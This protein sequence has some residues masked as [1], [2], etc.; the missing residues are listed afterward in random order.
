MTATATP[1][2]DAVVIW[3]DSARGHDDYSGATRGTALRTLDEAWG[4]VPR[5]RQLVTPYR[6]L[7]VRGTYPE[8]AIPNYLE[9]R[10]GTASA[11][12]TIE[13]ADGSGAA[14]LA[15]DLNIFDTR[16]LSLVA[17]AIVPDPPG[18][19]IHCE[20]CD[21]FTVTGATLSGGDRDA[22]E[23]VKINQS[24]NVVI[25]NSDISGAD[26]NAIDFVAVQGGRVSGNRI[27]NA[28]DWC[29]YVKGGSA[30]IRI[31]ANEIYDCGTGGFTAGQGTGF[32]FMS[33]PYLTYEAENIE[34]VGN[35]IH[36]T[37]GAGMGVNGG[38]TILLAEN[39]LERVGRRSHLLE[40][41]FGGRSCDGHPGDE[42]RERCAA[43]LARG[44]WGTTV[45][46]DGTNYV[47][48]PNKNVVVR[49]NVFA[50]PQGYQSQWQHFFISGAY[51]GA[52]Q[53]GSN[54]PSPAY[55]DDGL[56]ITG[57]VIHNGDPT[58]SMGIGDES[59]CQNSN[60]TCNEAQLLRDNDI[61][62][63]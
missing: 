45:V 41:G 32:Q 6:I 33:P 49:D 27:H 59:G 55:A 37:E 40:V 47:R 25:E 9:S 54:A 44:G 12:I 17:L 56:I 18:D 28:G 5:D 50:N 22:H 35:E 30:N 23:T 2:G 15:G 39:H 7:L 10:Y 4:R 52:A 63:R 58:M 3:V 42:G 43:Y 21:H 29:F 51:R 14:L 57:N 36:D 8:S 31:E 38:H 19:V 61:N 62:G 60:P 11:P 1:S 26:D 24:T 46:D 20:Q 48:I 13:S 34:F 53:V 16:Y